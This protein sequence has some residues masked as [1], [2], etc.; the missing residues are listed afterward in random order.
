MFVWGTA[1]FV[2][3]RRYIMLKNKGFK[4]RIEPNHDQHILFCKTFGCVRLVYNT[5]LSL[6][7]T[8]YEK[9]GTSIPYGNQAKMLVEL[10]K[11][12]EFLKE[13]DSIALQQ[14]LRHL[15]KAFKNFFEH[16]EVGYP[17]FKKKS[18]NRFSYTTMMVNDNIKVGDNYVVLPKVGKVKMKKH[19][20]IPEGYKITSATVS[21][22][23]TGKYYVSFQCEYEVLDTDKKLDAD[24]AVG[25]DYAM[26][27]LYIASDS[28]VGGYPKYYR[29]MKDK[30][31]REQRRLSKCEKYSKNYKKQRRKISIIHE[32][33][34]NQRKDYLH[35][36]SYL[37]A[38]KYDIVC[39]E[40]LDMKKMSQENDF[41]KSVHDNAWGMFTKE[42]GYKLDDS[43]KVL[44]K[45]DRWYPSSKTCHSCGHV[46]E[47]LELSQRY[48]VCPKCNR[49][50][51]RDA[52]ASM[53][54]L[55]EGIRKLKEENAPMLMA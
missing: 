8:T 55:N 54:I 35:K 6:C 22:T 16:P 25:L 10:K 3:E 42:L 33:I 34:A 38:N 13:V 44:V 43:N 7:T 27:G 37:I 11:E 4:Y 23:P 30:L 31:A 40:D 29:K 47:S 15:H 26:D 48:W 52:N 20:Q 32:K 49:V 9:D 53:N 14:S 19:R 18:K 45:V 51:N 5:F 17:N 2:D 36:L 1:F 39:I 12:K 50:H 28:T 21:R 24:K 41:G 46:I